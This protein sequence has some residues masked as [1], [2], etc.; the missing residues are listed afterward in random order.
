MARMMLPPNHPDALPPHL[1]LKALPLIALVVFLLILGFSSFYTIGPEEVGVVTR[2]GQF[3]TQTEPGLHFK[4][5]LGVDQVTPVKVRR[6]QKQEFGFRT[7][8]A[9]VKTTYQPHGQETDDESLMVTG[10][11]NMAVVEWIIQ[12]RIHDPQ[13][14]LFDVRNPEQTLRDASESVMREVIGDR[15]VDEVLTTGRQEIEA[16]ALKKLQGLIDNYKLGLHIENVILQDVT[17]PDPVK[18]SFNEVN[19]AQQERESSI[20]QARA[21]YNKAV[22]R[23]R[24]EALQKI[25]EAEGYRMERVNKAQGD[26][27]KFNDVLAAYLQAPEVTR[28]R[29]Y[30]ETMTDVI[31]KLGRKLVI[32]KDVQSVLPLLQLGGEVKPAEE[33]KE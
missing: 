22:P 6:Q 26:A 10:D 5:P 30:L 7:L 23:A 25:Q 32:D 15:T 9:G 11:L 2:F 16:T 18:A 20:N 21:D 4:M 27:S 12:Y 29:L 31:P 24:G 17:P 28:R 1:N 8:E 13:A 19:Q 3:L 14:F 33:V